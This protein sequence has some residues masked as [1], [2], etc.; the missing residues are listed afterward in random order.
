[1]RQGRREVRPVVQI[2]SELTGS[3]PVAAAAAAKQ[4]LLTWLRT[5]QRINSLPAEAWEGKA[6][7]LDESPVLWVAVESHDQMWALRYD[8]ADAREH[9]RQWRTE[10]IVAVREQAALVGIRLTVI[11][12]TWDVPFARSVPKVILDLVRSPGLSDYG[13]EL[14]DTPIEVSSP[15]GVQ[16]LVDLLE[17]PART[18]PVYVLSLGTS[19]EYIIDPAQLAQRTAGLAH[20]F[21]LDRDA[22]WLLSDALGNQ[23]SVYGDAVRTYRP[24]FDRYAGRW[25]DHPL[26][27]RDWARRRFSSS[28]AFMSILVETAIDDS[29]SLPNL[30]ERLP[31]FARIRRFVA[32]ARLASAKRG[33]TG[34]SEMLALFERDNDRLREDIV[35]AEQLIEEGTRTQKLIEEHRDQLQQQVFNLRTRLSILE[36]QIARRESSEEDSFPTGLEDIEQWAAGHLG[37]RVLLL[38]RALRALKRAEFRDAEAVAR[39]LNLL[40]C[41]YRDMRLGKAQRSVF[42]GA[43]AKLAIEVSPTGD[44]ATLLQWREQYEVLWGGEKRFLESHLKQ[45]S[46]REPRNCLRIYFFWDEDNQLVVVGHLPSHLTNEL[47]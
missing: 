16:G 18:R 47:T 2:T 40:G 43:A 39:S 42:E 20:V 36:D 46:S 17:N 38:P 30:E 14:G 7:E 37:G 24:G 22:S 33:H 23:L 29:V 28:S 8:K 12:G 10:A 9:G 26:A 41:E 27:T 34:S 15:A 4:C 31:S 5:K 25:S 35:A 19:G 45:G 11:T 21:T 13:T 3:D 32:E 1:M 6:F 44:H